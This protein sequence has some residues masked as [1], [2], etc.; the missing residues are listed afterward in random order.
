MTFMEERE[1]I[2][3]YLKK[4]KA[5]KSLMKIIVLRGSPA[6]GPLRGMARKGGSQFLSM[7]HRGGAPL[8]AAVVIA[9]VV[10]EVISS[11]DILLIRFFSV[12]YKRLCVITKRL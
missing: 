5:K 7:I 3:R 9:T 11:Y 10:I 12:V 8:G 2:A 6:S 1:S 4:G